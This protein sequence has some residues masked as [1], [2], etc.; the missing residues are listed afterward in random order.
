[1][2]KLSCSIS[3]ISLS[4]TLFLGGYNI[5]NAHL[6][7]LESTSSFFRIFSAVLALGCDLEF[8]ISD[9]REGE[10]FRSLANA[11]NEYDELRVFL[12]SNS[13][14]KIPQKICLILLVLII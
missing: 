1:M 7:F 9:S 6:I 13:A 12:S 10:M 5:P 11:R 4:I 3:V 14:F 8:I 2:T